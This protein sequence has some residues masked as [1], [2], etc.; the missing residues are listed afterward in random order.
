VLAGLSG[1]AGSDPQ[2]LDLVGLDRF[3][4]QTSLVAG[5][6]ASSTIGHTASSGGSPVLRLAR[7]ERTSPDQLVFLGDVLFAGGPI[8]RLTVTDEA[9]A[10]AVGG[11]VRVV[12][13]TDPTLPIETLDALGDASDLAVGGTRVLA[14]AG[15]DLVLVD[16]GD[17][18]TAATFTPAGQPTCLLAT[19]SVFL[20]FTT[21]GYVLVDPSAATTTFSEVA[22]P[23]LADLRDAYA[24]GASALIAG[25]A[26]SPG[27]SR[28]LRLDLTNPAAP[29]IVSGHEV[30]GAYVAF[31]WDGGATSVVAIHGQ[32]DGADPRAFHQGYVVREEAGG[33][34]DAG[35]PLTFWSQSRQPLAAH[36]DRL[37][38]V[39]GEGLLFLRIR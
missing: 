10:V 16:R 28:V 36:A 15:S 17:P 5:G 6:G 7:H 3:G 25:P 26:L 20:A 18:L 37:F 2:P 30:P 33:F 31:A 39:E 11:V 13:L 32:G 22:D 21:T 29:V 4:D 34:Q 19:G 1:C 9:A 24:D 27:S 38:A 8:A 12:D 35:V 14:V 23:A